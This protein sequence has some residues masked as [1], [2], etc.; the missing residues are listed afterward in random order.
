[1]KKLILACLV[2]SIIL[3]AVPALAQNT[4]PLGTTPSPL[5]QTNTTQPQ[6]NTTQPFNLGNMADMFNNVSQCANGNNF[7]QSLTCTAGGVLGAFSG[8]PAAQFLGNQS[9]LREG[10]FGQQ[11]GLGNELSNGLISGG[12][13]LLASQV[14]PAQVSRQA[15]TQAMGTDVSQQILRMQA[16]IQHA[17]NE[18]DAMHY[19][20]AS[21]QM[22]QTNRTLGQLL[23]AQTVSNQQIA[24]ML[25][26]NNNQLS[27]NGAIPAGTILPNQP[28]SPNP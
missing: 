15:L 18:I 19:A 22:M 11:L 24:Q 8:R 16:Q 27:R 17:G 26:T 10:F 25:Q 3:I 6:I 4:Q 14:G 28:T 20:M 1:M 12:S 7:L 21:T 2:P 13:Q 23:Q 9:V 5:P